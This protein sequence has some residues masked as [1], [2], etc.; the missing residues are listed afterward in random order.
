MIA[1]E[2][3]EIIWTPCYSIEI[4][5]FSEG[6]FSVTTTLPLTLKLGSNESIGWK[7]DIMIGSKIIVF[8]LVLCCAS[9]AFLCFILRPSL[10][11]IDS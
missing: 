2:E 1:T 5:A 3:I 6:A 8:V 4:K 9:K 10:V 11:V 7:P